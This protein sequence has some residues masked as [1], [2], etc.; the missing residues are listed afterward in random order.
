MVRHLLTLP[1]KIVYKTEL[2]IFTPW[3]LRVPGII[4]QGK[5]ALSMEQR[6]KRKDKQTAIIL[7]K[8]NKSL[9]KSLSDWYTWLQGFVYL[10]FQDLDSFFIRVMS[11]N[12]SI[13][14]SGML[15]SSLKTGTEN[16]CSATKCQLKS[17]PWR[18]LILETFSDYPFLLNLCYGKG[19]LESKRNP[20]YV[21]DK[22]C[23]VY[24]LRGSPMIIIG[25]PCN[26]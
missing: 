21:V 10:W 6:Y 16:S 11:T 23:N 8:L 7:W 4:L 14:S 17:L 12:R 5:P 1:Y 25:F 13:M 26:L 2:Q 15:F 9:L 3:K 19:L 18:K 24:R 22:P 20:I